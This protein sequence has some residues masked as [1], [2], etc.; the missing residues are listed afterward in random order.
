MQEMP[1]AEAQKLGAMA[2]FGEKYGETVRVVTMADASIEFCGGT[3]LDNTSKIGLFKIISE[4]SVA[5]GVRRIEAVTGQGVLDFIDKNTAL[6]NESAQALKLAN[7]TELANRCHAVAEEIKELERKNSAYADA[8]AELKSSALLSSVVVVEGLNVIVSKFENGKPDEIRKMAEWVKGKDENSVTVIACPTNIA[9]ACGTNAVARGVLAGKMV[10][11]IS[12][13]TGG[14]GGGRPDSA[15][16]GVGDASKLGE[17]LL[18]VD[19]ILREF[20]K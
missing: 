17:A 2:L 16:A 9:V 8:I 12:A 1:I 10:A 14:K 3:H 15:M 20:I 5:A 18:Q 11:K 13:L 7:P 19:D 6:I 4:S